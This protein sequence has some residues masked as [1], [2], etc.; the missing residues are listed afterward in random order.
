MPGHRTAPLRGPSLGGISAGARDEPRGSRGNRRG[1]LQVAARACEPRS[2]GT[3]DRKRPGLAGPGRDPRAGQGARNGMAR[4]VAAGWGT[5]S[6][7]AVPPGLQ[8][9]L[10]TGLRSHWCR[11]IPFL[12]TRSS[13][14]NSGTSSARAWHPTAL[15]AP[16]ARRLKR[17]RRALLAGSGAQAATFPASAPLSTAGERGLA[18]PPAQLSRRE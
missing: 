14:P 8:R 16:S 3:D 6:N 13:I 9:D 10:Q 11:P 5:R 7:G 15:W 17:P 1:R 4:P 18:E 2:W 12:P